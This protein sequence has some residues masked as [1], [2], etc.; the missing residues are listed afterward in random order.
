MPSSKPLTGYELDLLC[1][2][3]THLADIWRVLEEIGFSDRIGP[4]HPLRIMNDQLSATDQAELRCM[5]DALKN[6]PIG[7]IVFKG[8]DD[9][10]APE[11]D[12]LYGRS[13]EQ[14][15]SLKRSLRCIHNA[16]VS[17]DPDVNGVRESSLLDK[18][19][20]FMTLDDLQ[21]LAASDCVD[22]TNREFFIKILAYQ[23]LD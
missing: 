9:I 4:D 12:K 18:P 17:Q 13:C 11:G 22:S 15:A 20:L 10:T 1:Y 14:L 19:F 16:R 7:D 6:R 23:D 8:D 5:L 2:I 3:H 21:M